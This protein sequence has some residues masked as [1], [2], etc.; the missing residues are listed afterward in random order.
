MFPLQVRIQKSKEDFERRLKF[1]NQKVRKRLEKRLE[2]QNLRK[3]L[4]RIHYR[5]FKGICKLPFLFKDLLVFL[6]CNERTNSN[7]C[8]CLSKQRPWFQFDGVS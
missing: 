2:F 4:K 3:I 1:K 8:C 7:V 5:E 6:F